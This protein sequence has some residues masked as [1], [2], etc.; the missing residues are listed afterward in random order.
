M[1]CTLHEWMD[2]EKESSKPVTH[3]G[4]PLN[5]KPRILITRKK[6]INCK[7]PA[8]MSLTP[9]KVVRPKLQKPGSNMLFQEKDAGYLSKP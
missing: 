2:H 3:S 4:K 7:Q 1:S 8:A 6:Y 9:Q 5:L